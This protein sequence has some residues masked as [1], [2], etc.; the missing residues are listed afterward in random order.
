MVGKSQKLHGADVLMEIMALP[1]RT[2]A[3]CDF[4][5]FPAIARGQNHLLHCLP[6][7]CSKQSAAHFQDMGRVLEEVHH[8]PMEVLQKR[9]HHH[10]S[11]NF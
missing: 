8:L 6:E 11:T 1:I 5:V 9:D 2:S 4:W 3:P 10:T 7:A